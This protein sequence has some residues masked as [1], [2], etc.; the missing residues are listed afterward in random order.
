MSAE[1]VE[2]VTILGWNWFR[3]KG[4]LL[5]RDDVDLVSFPVA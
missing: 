1:E 3:D 2:P 5:V 4:K